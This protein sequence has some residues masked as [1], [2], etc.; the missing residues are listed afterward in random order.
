M[1]TQRNAVSLGGKMTR[2]E[3][4]AKPVCF[5]KCTTCAKSTEHCLAGNGNYMPKKKCDK[6][7]YYFMNAQ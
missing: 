1:V 3:Q 7:K 2:Y 4:H 5:R 6:C